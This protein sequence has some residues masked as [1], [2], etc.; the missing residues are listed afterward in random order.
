MIIVA[1][2]F[3]TSIYL[4]HKPWRNCAHTM[5]VRYEVRSIQQ[6]KIKM[7]KKQEKHTLLRIALATAAYLLD[8]NFFYY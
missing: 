4:H 7:N 5:Q 2:L 8:E 6:K 1:R 3:S